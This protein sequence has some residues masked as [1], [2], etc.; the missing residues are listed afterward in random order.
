MA[1]TLALVMPATGH[2][3]LMLA[4]GSLPVCSSMAPAWCD[5]VPPWPNDALHAYTF[6]INAENL[7]RWHNSLD[8]EQARTA[9]WIDLLDQIG[10]TGVLSR[11][12]L[13]D[14][15]L[16]AQGHTHSG[17]Q[18]HGQSDARTW[19]Q[20]LDHLQ[21]PVGEQRERVRLDHSK[22]GESVEIFRAFVAM[23]AKRAE[24]DR[25]L[26]AVSTASSRDPYDALAFYL[27]VFEQ[28]GADVVWLPL[29]G[30]V[31]AAR[32]AGQCDQLSMHQ[33]DVLGSWARAHVQPD[34]YARQVDFC[35]KPE[36]GPA[37]IEQIDGLFLNGGD[38]SLTLQAFVG[39]DGRSTPE[40]E[41]LLQR[42]R[43]GELV[44][45]G[46]SA[47][48]AVQSAPF[49]ISNGSSARA[50]TEG[51][52]EHLPPPAGCDRADSCPSGLRPD[53]LTFRRGGLGS[54]EPGI[55]DTH[56][57]ERWRQ[58]RLLQLLAQTETR[59]GVGVDETSAVIVDDLFVSEQA[60]QL[61]SLGAGSTWLIDLGPALV[62]NVQ[63]LSIENVTLHRMSSGA[64]VVFTPNQNKVVE[65]VPSTETGHSSC[66][67]ADGH[68]SFAALVDALP[69]NASEAACFDFAAHDALRA[70]SALAAQQ[71][72]AD[73]SGVQ[74]WSWSLQVGRDD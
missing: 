59:L 5:D 60:I 45:G 62:H 7:Q 1:L 64:R 39:P 13:T 55:V 66:E 15:I 41:L 27:Q 40:H 70:R 29:D 49:M 42:L 58:L 4:G 52:I 54:F 20:L 71:P 69:D 51:A 53:S 23:A 2:A 73:S 16:A 21:E 61:T 57:S 30:A 34:W 26:I 50:L 11:A 48:A 63:P 44:L 68:A 24:R 72:P 14:R 17:R 37:L 47:G 65:P 33:A 10:E 3:Q 38:Q 6:R 46:T 67:P 74:S 43:R 19:S 9:A 56:F 22:R 28:A 35:R 36:A 31:R 8:A 12:E 32:D 18:L 25:P